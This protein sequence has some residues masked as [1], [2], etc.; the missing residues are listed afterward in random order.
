[1]RSVQA[2][3]EP[4]SYQSEGAANGSDSQTLRHAVI[5]LALTTTL[6]LIAPVW[7][8]TLRVAFDNN[9]G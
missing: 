9:E 7:R 3:G 2:L 5:G 1:M 6:L 8:A 4:G